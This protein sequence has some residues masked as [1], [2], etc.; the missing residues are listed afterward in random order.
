MAAQQLTLGKNGAVGDRDFFVIDDQ[1][2]LL[3]IT[4]TGAFASW[5]VQFHHETA[6]LSLKSL[7]GDV[8]EGTVPEGRPLVVD[9]WNKASSF[10][11]ASG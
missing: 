3:S 10:T 7:E 6:V 5:R 9:F 11:L 8:L 1:Q 2:E 4:K